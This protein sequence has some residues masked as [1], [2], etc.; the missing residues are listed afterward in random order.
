MTGAALLLACTSRPALQTVNDITPL[1]RAERAFAAETAAHGWNAGVRA[2]A[3][4]D[5][6]IANPLPASAL[7]SLDPAQDTPAGSPLQWRPAFAGMARSGDLGFTSGPYFLR[8]KGY[9]G[10]YFTVWRRDPDG[11][12]KWIFDGGVNVRDDAPQAADAAV[13]SLPPSSPAGDG[14]T[15]LTVV[16]SL[17]AELAAAA[18]TDAASALLPRIAVDARV[19]RAASTRAEGRQAAKVLLA[20]HTSAIR[21]APANLVA[22]QAGDLVFAYGRADWNDDGDRVG[23]YARIWQLRRDGWWVVYDQLVPPR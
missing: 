22:S 18:G 13:T 9:V 15:A 5:A 20:R 12:W 19:N 17:E 21:F 4:S 14:T 23:S 1:V 7:A 3:A 6:V 10:H 11:R 2:F 16:R 8:D